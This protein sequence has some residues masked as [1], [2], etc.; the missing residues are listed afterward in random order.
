[1]S[2]I[3]IGARR[4]LATALGFGLCAGVAHATTLAQAVE[5]AWQRS[6]E[7]TAA[8]GALQRARADDAIPRSPWAGP[9][10]LELSHRNDLG[11]SARGARETELGV[12]V[13]L[14]LPGQRD[15]RRQSVEADTVLAQAQAARARWQLAGQVRAAL[16]EALLREAE[17]GQAA[18][19]ADALDALAADVARRVNAGDLA[20]ADGLAARADALQAR[21]RALE[22]DALRR[23]ARL[24]WQALT[25]LE[26]LPAPS[27]PVPDGADAAPPT[28]PGD[29]HPALREAQA[30]LDAARRQT[31]LARH[32]RRAAPELVARLRQDTGGRGEPAANAWG[33]ALRLPLGTDDRAVP[34]MAAAQSA[35]ALADAQL[36]QWRLQLEAEV[37][38][39]HADHLALQARRPGTA[40]RAALLRQRADLIERAFRAGEAPLPDLLRARAAAQAAALDVLRLDLQRE[41]AAG[42]LHHALGEQ[43]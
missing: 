38:V 11:L 9:P 25:G 17:A 4:L 27:R 30:R 6:S 13:P 42:L 39:R 8:Q 18:A 2:P 37:R 10:S 33:V 16:A 20:S 21:A 26:V 40:E 32:A 34:L 43:P 35:E 19:D 22:A 29:G 23:Q 36:R 24:H 41:Q 1:M 15:A 12:A 5:A 31:E 14:W 3:R 28:G 7:S